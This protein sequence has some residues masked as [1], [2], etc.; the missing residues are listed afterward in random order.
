LLDGLTIYG[1]F[2]DVPAYAGAAVAA[3]ALAGARRR[4]FHG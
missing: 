4:R 1:R 2:G 3:L